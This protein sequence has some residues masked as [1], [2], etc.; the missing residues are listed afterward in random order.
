VTHRNARD[1]VERLA[2]SFTGRTDPLHR[3]LVALDHDGTLSSIAPTPEAAVLAEGAREAISALAGRVDVL[4]LSG[5]GLDDLSTRFAGVAVTLISEHGLRART[6]DGSTRMLA[7]PLPPA[8]LVAVRDELRA[9][10]EGR[11]GWLVE[12]KGV[13]LAV[14][15]RLVPPEELEPTLAAVREVFDTA[16]ADD[17]LDGVVQDGHAVIELRPRGADKGAALARLVTE[18]DARPVLM[19]GDD[20][21]DEPALELAERLGGIGVL[22]GTEERASSASARLDDPTR[23]VELL[24]RLAALLGDDRSAEP[25]SQG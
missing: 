4:I 1:E 6:V 24:E 7:T 15:H 19:V 10:L 5:R 12:D 18:R 25:L 21:T 16:I 20:L 3:P 8:G 17:D 13:S 14:H 22:V 11:P 9:L 2:R 23:V